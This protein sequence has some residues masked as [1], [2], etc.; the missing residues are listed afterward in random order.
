MKTA[1][2]CEQ[3]QLH[4]KLGG[5]FLKLDKDDSALWVSDLPRRN[6]DLQSVQKALESAGIRCRLDK[7]S[8][9]WHLDWAEE[10]WERFLAALPKE[11]PSFPQNESLH[12]QYS[13][14]RFALA[15]PCASTQEGLKM[16]RA[17][18]KGET[19]IRKMHEHAAQML[20]SGQPVAYGAGRVLAAMIME[21]ERQ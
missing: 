17:L 8:R 16:V 4:K 20:R 18:L 12:E 5:G 10:R 6:A 2:A 11:C 1:L 7:K 21:E 9:M 19:N 3:A 13:F 14:C 15:H